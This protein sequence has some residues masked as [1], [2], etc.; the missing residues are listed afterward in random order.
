MKGRFF[1]VSNKYISPY[2]LLLNDKSGVQFKNGNN[3]IM[4][5]EDSIPRGHYDHLEKRSH[6]LREFFF[7]KEISQNLRR[8]ELK[9]LRFA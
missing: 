5:K 7:F 1:I 3:K 2:P 9:Y 4:N 8:A 6:D